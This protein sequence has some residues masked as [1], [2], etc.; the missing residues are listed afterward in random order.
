MKYWSEVSNNYEINFIEL[1][2]ASM[3]A[4]E[5][6]FGSESMDIT[7]MIIDSTPRIGRQRSADDSY[8]R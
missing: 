5:S 2:A 7:D 6:S 4:G 3:F 8:E 1:T